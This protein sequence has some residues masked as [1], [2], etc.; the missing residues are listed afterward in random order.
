VIFKY[1]GAEVFMHAKVNSP[2]LRDF[3]ILKRGSGNIR[4]KIA[5][6]G[7]NNRSL[8]APITNRSMKKRAED[9]RSKR[10]GHIARKVKL[11]EAKDP[12]LSKK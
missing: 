6:W 8:T 4:S 2:Y 1:C 3:K 11:Q 5:I 10:L 7:K 9:Y 12:L